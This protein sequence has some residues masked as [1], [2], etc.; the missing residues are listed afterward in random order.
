MH[1]TA[2]AE[3]ER[4]KGAF[5]AGIGGWLKE[6]TQYYKE[7]WYR[8][9]EIEHHASGFGNEDLISNKAGINFSTS[10]LDHLRDGESV[11]TAFS[12]WMKDVNA[13]PK[14]DPSAKLYELPLEDPGAPGNRH[15]GYQ[16]QYFSYV[17]LSTIDLL[18]KPIEK[19]HV[20]TIDKKGTGLWY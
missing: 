2:A 5:L 4:S 6:F 18:H 12:E 19:P 16:P 3:L 9:L 20:S 10:Y 14:D 7:A 17:P 13:L 11:A 15:H 8:K 1:F